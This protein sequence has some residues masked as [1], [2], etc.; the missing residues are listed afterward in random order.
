MGFLF[1]I[2]IISIC[3]VLFIKTIK[4]KKKYN[5]DSYPYSGGG[6]SSHNDGSNNNSLNE[7]QNF[8][9]VSVTYFKDGG[10]ATSMDIGG[11]IKEYSGISSVTEVKDQYG[12]NVGN[13]KTYD[14]GFGVSKTFYEDKDGKETEITSYKW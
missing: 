4:G 5:F 6:Y 10:K 12:Q 9:D 13:A 14:L 2:I 1:I 8:G 3:L 7:S 11:K